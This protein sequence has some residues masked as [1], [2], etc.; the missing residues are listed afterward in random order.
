ML[1]G[2]TW[3]TGSALQSGCPYLALEGGSR[4]PNHT[5]RTVGGVGRKFFAKTINSLGVCSVSSTVSGVRDT[6]VKQN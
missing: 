3:V 1:I 2:S 5:W 4:D 6:D